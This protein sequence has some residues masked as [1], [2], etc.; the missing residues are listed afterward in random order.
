MLDSE[1]VA[2]SAFQ[3]APGTPGT[4]ATGTAGLGQGD[5]SA[6]VSDKTPWTVLSD[7]VPL[8]LFPS[9][10]WKLRLTCNHRVVHRS[11]LSPL[12][13]QRE[14]LSLRTHLRLLKETPDSRLMRSG[15][16]FCLGLPTQDMMDSMVLQDSRLPLQD[17]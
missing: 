17:K 5:T 14:G 4:V 9:Q 12:K 11:P 15:E 6:Q 3:D 7:S 16:L 10:A 1:G 8:T 13:D 2:M